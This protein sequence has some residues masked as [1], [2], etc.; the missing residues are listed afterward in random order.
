VA[1]HYQG[2][3]VGDVKLSRIDRR[4]LDSGFDPLFSDELLFDH[5]TFL[6]LHFLNPDMALPVV[7]HHTMD[8]ADADGQGCLLRRIPRSY[9]A[10]RSASR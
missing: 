6:P 9:N 10:A 5:A 1:A 2:A 4:C 7:P 3:C 8:A